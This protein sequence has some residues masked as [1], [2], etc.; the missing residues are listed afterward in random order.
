MCHKCST[1]KSS[2]EFHAQLDQV[3]S[4][5]ESMNLSDDANDRSDAVS[6]S[7]ASSSLL[8]DRIRICA[9]CDGFLSPDEKPENE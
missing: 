6:I 4:N 8:E 7:S 1:F 5:T 2:D 3:A 9:D